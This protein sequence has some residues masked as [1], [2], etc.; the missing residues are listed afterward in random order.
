MQTAVKLASPF[1]VK[2][3]AV[4]LAGIGGDTLDRGEALVRAQ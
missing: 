1:K 4:I 2:T 3:A